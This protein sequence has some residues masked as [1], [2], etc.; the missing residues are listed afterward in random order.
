MATS[1]P[2]SQPSS[3]APEHGEPREEQ[4]RPELS[5]RLTAAEFQRWYWLKDELAAFARELGIRATGSKALLSERIA[6]KL[7]GQAFAEPTTTA[8]A[9]GSRQL[10]GE[11]TDE[12]VIP[13]G[14]RSSQLVR[15]WMI[16]QVG[17]AFHFDAEMRGFFAESDGTRTMRDAVA[18]WHATRDQAPR[19][20][21]KQF[22]YN[23]FTRAW[24]AEH[25]AGD[26]GELLAAWAAY[27]SRPIDER[28]RA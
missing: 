16:E 1:V 24:H 5:A 15:A 4:A 10:A 7:A 9:R 26:R 6:A 12:T 25:P 28:G 20:I 2:P 3:S 27:R 18:H 11:L 21:D 19:D 23:R 13:A 14:Q 8:R 17:E 22:E